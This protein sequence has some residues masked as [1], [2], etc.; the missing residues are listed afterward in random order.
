VIGK[1][2]PFHVGHA[3]LVRQALRACE[4]VTVQVLGASVESVSLADRVRWISEEH[5][6]VRVVATIDDAPVDFLSEQAWD[7]H[8]AVIQGLLDHPVDAVF[9]SDEYGGE[10]AAR[11]GAVWER[12][13][14]GRRITPVSGTAIRSD[15]ARQWHEL[16]PAVRA[17][18]GVRV[19]VLGAESTGST[20]LAEA[21]ATALGTLWVAEYGREYSLEREGGMD[22][23]WASHEFDLIVDR[24]IAAEQAALRR[25]P[26][27]VLVCD[28]D[29]LATALWHERYVGERA[30]RIERRALQHPPALY[31]LSGDEIPFVQDGTRDG[32]HIRHRMQER[33]RRALAAQ[34][35][36]WLEVHGD[37][38]TRVAASLPAVHDAVNR[39]LRFATPLE[40]RPWD[41][42][43]ALRRAGDPE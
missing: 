21:L 17:D 13:D 34:P 9:T 3:Y 32:E 35:V 20:T 10:L 7:E 14:P 4:T 25:C 6:T 12:V 23:P 36:P 39:A 40:Q 19:V 43:V 16:T 27:P 26:T 8:T 1:F 37:V 38:P 41:E 2:Y 24:Q 29:V 5:P 15:L 30:A 33:F 31:V 18:L 28:T 42:Q 11:L 22:A